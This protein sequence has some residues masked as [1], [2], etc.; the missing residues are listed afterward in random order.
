MVAGARAQSEGSG[1]DDDPLPEEP[2]AEE[3]TEPPTDDP[4]EHERGGGAGQGDRAGAESLARVGRSLMALGRHAEA[5]PMLEQSVAAAPSGATN[6]LLG[7]CLERLGK[8]ASA[9]AYY[10]QAAAMLAGNDDAAAEVARQQALRLEPQVPKLTISAG[11]RPPGMEVRR[12]DVVFGSGVLGVPLAVDPGTQ[13]IEVRAPGHLPWSTQV[14]VT[15]G[16]RHSVV[17]PA[18]T[19]LE[20]PQRTPTVEVVA[21]RRGSWFYAGVVSAGVGVAAMATGALLGA[22]AGRDVNRAEADDAL[23]G[24]DRS[25]TP[26]GREV[27]DDAEAKALGSTLTLSIGAAALVGG[28]ILVLIDPAVS[29][30][31]SESG[32]DAV[33]VA[34]VPW[35]GPEGGGM[36]VELRF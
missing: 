23:C 3:A 10:R 13:R 36:L 35:A 16:E 25:C 33:A 4:E 26:A 29:R 8:I 1:E 32:A 7:E 15:A 34:A 18:L 6:L 2:Y 12:N 5:C 22:S 9:W 19:P 28:F 17:V 11:T 14:E 27:V 30:S 20:P 31:G 24:A 21:P